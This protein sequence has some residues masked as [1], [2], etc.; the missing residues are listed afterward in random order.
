MKSI[1][2][3]LFAMVVFDG[4][5]NCN[6]QKVKGCECNIDAIVKKNDG[7]ISG[8]NCLTKIGGK[9]FCYVDNEECG[10]AN[11]ARFRPKKWINYSLCDC[12]KYPNSPNCK[13]EVTKLGD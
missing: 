10:E 7:T 9:F 12:T 2:L 4:L 5:Q 11:T 6:S 13:T 8:G 3:I 1:F